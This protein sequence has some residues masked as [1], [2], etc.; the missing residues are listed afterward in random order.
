[1]QTFGSPPTRPLLNLP[2]GRRI[3]VSGI[4]LPPDEKRVLAE[5]KTDESMQMD[6]IVEGR[7]EGLENEVSPSKIFAARFEL[8]PAGR[9]NSFLVRTSR[10]RSQ[11]ASGG[12]SNRRLRASTPT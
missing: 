2:L 10:R 6:G 12:R 9:S 7:E 11:Q 3:S 4:E 5:L 1:M 8:E